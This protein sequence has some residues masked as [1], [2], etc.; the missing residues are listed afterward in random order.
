MGKVGYI[1]VVREG[2]L[3]EVT[4]ELR[5]ITKVNW[6]KGTWDRSA[7]FLATAYESPTI[8]KSF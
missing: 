6:G 5:S 7:L 3:E 8:S 2:S 4:F 1:R